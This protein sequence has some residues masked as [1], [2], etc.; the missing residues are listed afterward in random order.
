MARRTGVRNEANGSFLDD[1]ELDTH[2]VPP[3]DGDAHVEELFRRHGLDVAEHVAVRTEAHGKTKE[4]KA[5]WVIHRT[6]PTG[7]KLTAG[8]G[9]AWQVGG[10]FVPFDSE[11]DARTQAIAFALHLE[12]MI[13]RVVA[14]PAAS[15]SVSLPVATHLKITDKP[16]QIN[17]AIKCNSSEWLV[18]QSI[19]AAARAQ[20]VMLDSQGKPVDSIAD[21]I[22]LVL[23]KISTELG[24]I[25]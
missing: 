4:Y 11:D 18:V 1:E 23:A 10:F 2:D 24:K 21:V 13:E 17:L 14:V 9:M 22:R 25:V 19:L 7:R 3:K 6:L 16:G 12:A 8:R 5:G 20:N 15:I